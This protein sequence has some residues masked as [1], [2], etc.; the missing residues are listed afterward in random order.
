V[1]HDEQ[2]QRQVET[3]VKRIKK[4]AKGRDTLLAYSVFL[5]TLG[6]LFIVPV[7]GG[8]YLG[9]WLDSRGAGYSIQWTVSLIMLGVIIGAV[10]VYLRVKE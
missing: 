6:L 2:L 1:R 4:A 10:N 7:I 3:Q 8:A 9:L 5:G